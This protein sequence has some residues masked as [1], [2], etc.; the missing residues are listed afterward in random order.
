MKCRILKA[1][2]VVITSSE[3]QDNLGSN[4]NISVAE[5]IMLNCDKTTRQKVAVL[6]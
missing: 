3:F 5:N 1:A 2:F 6:S 4:E